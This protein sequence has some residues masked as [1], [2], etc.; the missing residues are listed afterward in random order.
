[1]QAQQT[2]IAR[3]ISFGALGLYGGCLV[4]LSL[5]STWKHKY[6]PLQNQEGSAL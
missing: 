3:C 4:L 5:L 6:K 1:V 2:Y